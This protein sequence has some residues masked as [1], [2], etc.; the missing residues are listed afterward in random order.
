MMH[1][2]ATIGTRQSTSEHI[3]HVRDALIGKRQSTSYQ[4]I[5]Y[6]NRKTTVNE[7]AINEC[8]NGVHR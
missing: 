3:I 4:Y 8:M 5:Q 6:I 1:T 7:K 2:G